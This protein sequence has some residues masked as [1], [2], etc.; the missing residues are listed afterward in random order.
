[1]L[2]LS[3]VEIGRAGVGV[4]I[5]SGAS[6]PDISTPDALRRALVAARS[7]AYVGQGATASILEG[8]FER[9]GIAAEMR[10][11]TRLV[12]G[13]AEAVAQGEAEIGFTQVS[14]ILPVAGAVLAGPL[15]EPL[16]VFTRFAAA[17]AV[18]GASPDLARMVLAIMTSSSGAAA[19]AASGM[20]PAIAPDRLPPIP[21]SQMTES[22]AKAAAEF[23]VIR[24]GAELSGPFFPL[25]RSPELMVR[26]SS[27][28][29]YL[30]YRSAL[31]PRLSEFVILLTAREWG[32]QYEWNAHYALALKAGV[33]AEIAGAIAEGRR[34]AGLA[35]DHEALYDFCDEL[36][37]TR[38]VS[39]ATYQRALSR[40]GEQG[41]VDAVGLVGYYSMLAMVLNTART[42]AGTSAAPVLR[43]LAK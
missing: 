32:Q 30:R 8:I 7:V 13:A 23:K 11:K 3:R 37:R 26:T 16:Q 42:P 36:L 17:A 27:L 9:F 21:P 41:V 38:A 2:P 6:P 28:G 40:F 43:P 12:L 14:E 24:N 34:P 39:D 22:Q 10:A 4:A 33:S 1:V 5:R 25:L 20:Q 19:I 31:P 15:P 18:N 29:E 35:A